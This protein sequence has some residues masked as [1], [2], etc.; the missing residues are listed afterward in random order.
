MALQICS[1]AWH[2][3]NFTSADVSSVDP[4]VTELSEEMQT[5][6]YSLDKVL[7]ADETGLWWKV[8]PSKFLVHAMQ[9]ITSFLLH[10]GSFCLF[11][12]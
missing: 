10:D 1:K 12:S 11:Q 6:G 8:M 5:K 4:F 7:N 9:Y 3:C 2:S